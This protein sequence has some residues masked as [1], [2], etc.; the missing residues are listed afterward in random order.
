MFGYKTIYEYGAEKIRAHLSYSPGHRPLHVDEEGKL[1]EEP[2][3]TEI[4][5]IYES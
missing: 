5:G 4:G 3:V 2:F 1:K